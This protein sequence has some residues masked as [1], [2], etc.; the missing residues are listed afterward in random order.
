MKRIAILGST[1]SIGVN[2]LDVISKHS[3]DFEIV[4]LTGGAN[5]GLLK[6]QIELFR[7]EIACVLKEEDAASLQE[8]LGT[9]GRC[10]VLWGVDGYC[11]VARFSKAQMIVSAMVGAAGLLP[12]WEAI[13][14]GKDVA[15]ANKETL[16]MAGQIIINE[17]AER[18]IRILPVDS[19]HCAVF[20]CLE[21]HSRQD[22]KRI[23]LTA[24]GGPFLHL[25]ENEFKGIRPEDALRHPNW[26]MGRKITVDSASMMNKGLEVIEARWLFG[27]DYD[28]IDVVI[29]PQSVIHSMVEYRDGS[30]LAQ[31]GIPDMRVPISYAMYYP[32]RTEMPS[33]RLD[34]FRAERLEF[35]KPDHKRFPNLG[36]AYEAGR[37]GGVMPAVM[38]AAN[39][40]AVELFLNGDIGFTEMPVLIQETM[41]ECPPGLAEKIEHVMDADRWARKRAEEIYRENR[42]KRPAKKERET[43]MRSRE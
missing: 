8:S 1:G 37:R 13:R 19:E 16:V 30:I 33:C 14:A 17:A 2:A 18:G 36:M 7:P 3:G 9:A 43:G 39:E 6:K 23:I 38:N 26:K 12:T 10:K 24:S 21:G 4:G 35:L 29:H 42:V 15:L 11:E 27:L 22:V 25:P 40:I 28:R 5:I 34:L 32:K 31:M 20:Q 41:A